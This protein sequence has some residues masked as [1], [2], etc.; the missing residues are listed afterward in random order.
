[1]A[2]HFRNTDES[3]SFQSSPEPYRQNAGDG[4]GGFDGRDQGGAYQQY[5]VEIPRRREKRRWPKVLLAV[6]LVLVVAA[7]V[8]A[9]FV[10]Q[11]VPTVREDA[12]VAVDGAHEYLAA[13][14][15][16]DQDGLKKS[17]K[18]VSESANKLKQDLAG[19]QWTVASLVPVFGSD[20]TSVRVVANVL[21]D[22]ADEGL[23][24]MAEGME[25][26]SLSELMDDGAVNTEA[27]NNLCSVV[28]K[29]TPL[30]SRS[31]K[32]VEGL[33]KA[34]I[35]QVAKVLEPA[36]EALVGANDALE[37]ISPLMG[38][39]PTLLGA[40]GEEKHY[41][42]LASN[43][44]EVYAS[45]GFVGI[46]GMLT[47]DNGALELGDF[48]SVYDL[49]PVHEVSAGATDEEIEIFGERVDIIHGD[50]TVTPDFSRV[51]QLYYNI[52]ETAQDEQLDG[53]IGVDPVFLQ[54]LLGLVNGEI[55]TSFGITVD[56]TN[57]ASMMLNQCLFYWG[58]ESDNTD[59]F[60]KEVASEAFKKILSGLGDVDTL[61]FLQAI[62]D[63]ARE[64]RC[65][66]WVS[67]EAIELDI[68]H[69]GYGRELPH[70]PAAPL[71]GVFTNDRSVSKASYYLSLDVEVGEPSPNA[72]GSK[73][74]PVVETL[75]HNMDRSLLWS[76]PRYIQS[77]FARSASDARS[78][79]ELYEELCL[80]APAGGTIQNIS[81]DYRDSTSPAPEFGW[82]E[83]SYQGLQ[84]WRGN[85][86][87]DA[88]ET[89]VISFDVVTSPEATEPL[90][91]RTT[92]VVPHYIRG[93]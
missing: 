61:E 51:G 24:P 93:D 22:V 26:A 23:V 41:L 14:K 92:P 39:L 63:S 81:V 72:D 15:A 29:M 16:G 10:W 65:A 68:Q 44:A 52:W 77:G 87:L 11:S 69:A 6:V 36:R 90:A 89:C 9:F 21:A 27:L 31:A 40:D 84:L 17:A 71:V 54:T 48:S 25:I 32:E 74:Y 85:M 37:Q 18:V 2:R 91:V 57:A 46:L 3:G 67:D 83:H 30:I 35:E 13:A 19:A 50:H 55:E 12:R 8:D 79:A 38:D 7:G 33:P 5:Q 42:I 73:T 82:V 56:G 58:G 80:V 76:L 88:G 45:G 64:G 49:L 34:H 43:T 1:M 70:D 62:G 47:V 59:Q 66:A 60:Y 86:R 28:E 20:I 78:V 75:R 53:V 4:Y